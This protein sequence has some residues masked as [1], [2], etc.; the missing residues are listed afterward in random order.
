MKNCI[1]LSLCILFITQF[2]FSQDVIIRGTIIEKSNGEAILNQK[3]KL[4]RGTD[5]SVIAGAYT[6]ENGFFSIPKVPRGKVIIKIES[7]QY[8][9][10]VYPVDIIEAKGIL[11]FKF[12]MKKSSN[13]KNLEEFTVNSGEKQKKNEVLT[14]TFKLDPK[15]LSTI[16]NTTAESDLI[17]AISVVPG[18]VTTGD[19]G[20]QLYVRGGTPIQNKTILD[21]MT[22]YNPFHSIGFFSIFETELIKNVD[23]YTGGFDAQYG[24]RISSIMDVSY[25]DGDRVKFGGK[26]STSPFLAKLIVEGPL[27]RSKDGKPGSGSY[28]FSAKHSL[29]DN[30]SKTLYPRI[31]G[32]D[33]LPFTFTDLYGK[34]TFNSNGGSKFSVFGFHNRDSV[35]FNVADLD[36][37]ASGLGINFVLVP[38]SSA[39]LIKGHVNGSNYQTSFTEANSQ[40][41]TSK[42]GGFDMGFD[43]TYFLPNES[44]INYGFNLNGFNTEF[45]TFNELQRKI[46]LINFTT[47]IGT[48]VNWRKKI[49]DKWVIQPSLRIQVYSSLG[50]ISPE[51]RIGL[52]YNAT[53]KWRLKLSGGR[54]SQNFTSASSDKDIVNLFNGLL[55]APTNV[56]ENFINEFQ[57]V[58][59]TKNGLQYAWHAILGT[60]Y[61]LGKR[62]TI[63]LEGYYKYFSQLS[64]INQNKLYDDVAQFS[65]IDDVF[66]KDF[67]LETGQTYGGDLLLKYNHKGLFIWSGYSYSVST[68]WDG[69]ITYFPVFDRRHNLNFVASYAFGKNKS[70]EINGR[71]NLG[72]GLPFTPTAGYYQNENFQ[73]GVTT[74]YVTNNSTTVT[75]MLGEFNSERMPY[76]HRMDVTVKKRIKFK[77]QSE[78]EI[79]G[80]ITNVYNRRNIFYVNRVTNEEIYQFPILP[81][82]GVSYNF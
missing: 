33:G 70:W 77:N 1:F 48:Y 46:E 2:T 16:P 10:T 65:D 58:K 52:K 23:I 36:W 9:N 56:Q 49:G 28:V 39:V 79:V 59:K 51:P 17:G 20:G 45:K 47:E 50:T 6:D 40:P 18:V 41:R 54:F 12:E 60:E 57:Q 11:N 55:S 3:V 53:N 32:G 35:N 14:G 64:N 27:Q 43:F 19:Q 21:G 37:T 30:T 31:N 34:I 25:R 74:D 38:S 4:L 69:F 44:E 24:G 80:S 22:I 66:K 13:M 67:I 63:N 73:N 72:S 15:M 75:T 68:R 8:S 42:I 26:V 7:E 78:L 76:Y 82:F 81:S 71:W 62:I 61:D 29:L 5:S